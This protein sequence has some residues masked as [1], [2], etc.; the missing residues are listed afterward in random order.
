MMMS[1]VIQ[2]LT[3]FETAG[4]FLETAPVD[5]NS[6]AAA[7]GVRVETLPLGGDVSGKI[8]RSPDGGFVISLNSHDGHRRRRFTLAHE[9]AHYLLHRDLIGDGIT[10]SAMYR[11]SLSNEV[12]RQANRFAA[13]LLMPA[14][15]VRRFWREGECSFAGMALRFD[16]SNEAA[17]IRLKDL[18]YG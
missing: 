5:L 8:E 1:A 2:D 14:A 13:D 4:R 12:E 11:S 18:G 7:V 6:M 10:D 9:L 17:R 3:P 16:V 15:L